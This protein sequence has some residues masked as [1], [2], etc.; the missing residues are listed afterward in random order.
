VRYSLLKDPARQT[1]QQLLRLW[2]V[3]QT[4]KAMFR[5]ALLYGELRSVYKVPKDQ[6]KERLE[7][8]LAWACPW[9]PNNAG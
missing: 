5:A 2:E 8:W 7:A 6:A 1:T 3:Q 9:P 4:N